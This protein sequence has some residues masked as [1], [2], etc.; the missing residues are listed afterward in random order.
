MGA[1]TV[2]VDSSTD[3]EPPVSSK[4]AYVSSPASKPQRPR[5]ALVEGDEVGGEAGDWPQ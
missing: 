1:V 4:Q 2:G 5:P 3:S